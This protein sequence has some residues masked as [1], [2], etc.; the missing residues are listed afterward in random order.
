MAGEQESDWIQENTLGTVCKKDV[1]V[2]D[3][4]IL[5]IACHRWVHKRCSGISGTVDW[6]NNVDFHC[7]RCLVCDSV[8]AVVLRKVKIYPGVKIEECVSKFCFL[9]DTPWLRWW[10]GGITRNTARKF[11]TWY[12][13]FKQRMLLFPNSE[14]SDNNIFANF[15]Y[16]FQ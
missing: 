14:S 3:N 10:C 4:F 6:G 9:G 2:T 16:S 11:V 15:L 12:F 13:Q 1:H 5:C 7:R 8:T